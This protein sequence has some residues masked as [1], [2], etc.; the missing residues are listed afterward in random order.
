MMFLK[1]RDDNV[2]YSEIKPLPAKE[3]SHKVSI[4]K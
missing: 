1:N 2:K 3:L 4:L